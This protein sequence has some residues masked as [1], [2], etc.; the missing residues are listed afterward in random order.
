[1]GLDQPHLRSG[2]AQLVGGSWTRSVLR[3]L[4]KM[5][6]R[7]V[8]VVYLVPEPTGSIPPAVQARMLAL[9]R[10]ASVLEEPIY[11]GSW[12]SPKDR[13]H[14][15]TIVVYYCLAAQ[16]KQNNVP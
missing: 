14:L 7:S 10:A 2:T 4:K 13:R 3:K 8:F 6:R 12:I 5:H 15:A 11:L 1:M 9:V 16:Y